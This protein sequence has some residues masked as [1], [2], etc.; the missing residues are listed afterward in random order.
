[1]GLTERLSTLFLGERMPAPPHFPTGAVPPDVVLRTGRLVPWLGGILSGGSGSASAVTLGRTIV[2]NPDA[3]LTL[4]LLTHE[5]A[6]VRQWESDAL[7]P[8]R[9]SLAT[10]RHGYRDNPYEVEAR[11]LAHAA[12]KSTTREKTS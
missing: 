4:S 10:L 5:L 12:S 8:I 11:N 9:Y 1:L 2:V 3:P 6:H 7:F